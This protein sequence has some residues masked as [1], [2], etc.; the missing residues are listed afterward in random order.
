MW[1]GNE[2]RGKSGLGMRFEGEWPRNAVR[3][4]SGLGMR[5]QN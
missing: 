5:L 1:P 4:K 2:V 3:G